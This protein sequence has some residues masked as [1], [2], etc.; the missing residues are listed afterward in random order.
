MSLAAAGAADPVNGI[1]SWHERMLLE[2]INRARVSPSTDL[3]LCGAN[4]SVAELSPGCYPPVN[5][6]HMPVSLNRAADFHSKSMQQNYFLGHDTP[7]I[8]RSDID[9][10]FPLLCNGNSLCASSGAGT[11]LA[12]D[13]VALFGATLSGES[14][15]YGGTT[16]GDVFYTWLLENGQG[17]DCTSTVHNGDR[18]MILKGGPAVGAGISGPD[19]SQFS[20]YSTLDFGPTSEL[21]PKIPSGAHWASAS[22]GS[23]GQRYGSPVEF[24]ANWFDS[25]SPSKAVVVFEGTARPLSLAR[26]TGTNGAWTATVSNINPNCQR[27]HFEFTDSMGNMFRY[28]TLGSF[29]VG[30]TNCADWSLGSPVRGDFNA[31]AKSDVV[32]RNSST[33]DNAMWIMNGSTIGTPALLPRVAD[34]HWKIAA[35]GDFDADGKNDIIWRN[36]VTGQVV[37]WLMDGT[38]LRSATSIDYVNLNWNIAGTSSLFN[39]DK[40]D[41]IWRNQLT[42]ENVAWIMNGADRTSAFNLPAIGTNYAV[43]G[44]GDFDGDGVND[45]LWRNSVTGETL[46][47]ILGGLGAY[48]YTLDTVADMNYKVVGVGDVDGDGKADVVWW[49]SATGDVAVWLMD[50]GRRTGGSLVTTVSTTSWHVEGVGDFDGDGKADLVWRNVNTGDTV[51]WLMNGTTLKQGA[52]I[53]TVS[54][55]N[56]SIVAPR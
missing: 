33:G 22:S 17:A 24:W 11:T 46:V 43:A 49:N 41:V 21:M 39:D 15:S 45:I 27:Y 19:D 28:P 13:R 30:F 14:I 32:W 42:G 23:S 20:G 51:V 35:V 47:W 55:L 53:T 8:I 10:V 52:Y 2:L 26:G 18:Y 50:G 31:D 3:S 44:M 6:L 56:W 38:S 54:D 37:V 4:C 34:A 5:P 7:F 25:D 16:P 1:P 36:N 48:S 40:A 29:G 12:A 9:S